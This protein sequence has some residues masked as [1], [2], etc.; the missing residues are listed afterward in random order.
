MVK[1]I[2][3]RFFEAYARHVGIP[4][5]LANKIIDGRYKPYLSSLDDQYY[6]GNDVYDAKVEALRASLH[7]FGKAETIRRLKMLR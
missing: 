7:K 4:M 3:K 2:S 6:H 1:L 5:N